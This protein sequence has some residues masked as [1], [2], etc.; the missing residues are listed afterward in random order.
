M[1]GKFVKSKYTEM[2]RHANDIHYQN[3]SI[4]AE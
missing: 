2:I 3:T 1:A 4:D